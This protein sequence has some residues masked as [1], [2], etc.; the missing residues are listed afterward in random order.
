M[1]RPIE[2]GVLPEKKSLTDIKDLNRC[3]TINCLGL[4]DIIKVSIATA[5]SLSLVTDRNYS[6]ITDMLQ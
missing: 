6:K 4:G 1:Y 3:E 2:L 5:P